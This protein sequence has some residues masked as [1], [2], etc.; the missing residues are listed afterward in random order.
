MSFEEEVGSIWIWNHIPTSLY[1]PL[2][3]QRTRKRGYGDEGDEEMSFEEEVG[4]IWIWNHIPTSLY[5]PLLH[6]VQGRH[7]AD[8]RSHCHNHTASW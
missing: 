5:L 4:S 1:L 2:L 6:S 3:T 8:T 7:W